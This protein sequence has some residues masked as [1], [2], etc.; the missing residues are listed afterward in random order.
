MR[1]ISAL[2]GLGPP[3]RVVN[4]LQCGQAGRHGCACLQKIEHL[5]NSRGIPFADRDVLDAKAPFGICVVICV[6]AVVDSQAAG[7]GTSRDDDP[8][9]IGPKN[10]WKFGAP[11]GPPRAVTSG[12]VPNT[13]AR[14]VY[15][16]EDFVSARLRTGKV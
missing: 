13:H 2:F 8:R 9:A 11:V 16:D 14:S 7:S 1:R 6:C 3:A 10:E 5:G 12:P 15:G 4:S